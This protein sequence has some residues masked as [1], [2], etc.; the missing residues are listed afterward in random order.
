MSDTCYSVTYLVQ[1]PK[2]L[3]RATPSKQFPQKNLIAGP[4]NRAYNPCSNGNSLDPKYLELPVQQ[5]YYVRTLQLEFEAFISHQCKN[6]RSWCQ[7][8]RKP[9]LS[10]DLDI[11]VR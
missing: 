7:T 2:S 11:E 8:L 10:L 3:C 4:K 6:L 9:K 1:V 5:K